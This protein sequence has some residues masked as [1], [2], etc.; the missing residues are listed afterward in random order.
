MSCW[1]LVGLA[2]YANELALHILTSANRQALTTTRKK[3]KSP[4]DAD[5]AF[6][7]WQ[8]WVFAGVWLES[9]ISLACNSADF[10]NCSW[11]KC[12]KLLPLLSVLPTAIFLHFAQNLP[13]CSKRFPYIITF[14]ALVP[15]VETSK[16]EPTHR[17]FVANQTDKDCCMFTC[18]CH[19]KTKLFW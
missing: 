4:L 19:S 15:C 5:A 1:F 11:V 9:R 18:F 8:V 17:K 3:E 14:S 10:L 2:D 7:S 6:A 16:A 12:G 13:N